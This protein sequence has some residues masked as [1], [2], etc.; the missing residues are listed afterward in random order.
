MAYFNAGSGSL[1]WYK[2]LAFAFN[3]IVARQ[4]IPYAKATTAR[5]LITQAL[6]G[7]HAL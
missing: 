4:S 1:P 3:P 7:F 6:G 5:A 2:E